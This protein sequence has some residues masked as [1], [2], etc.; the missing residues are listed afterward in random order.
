M[1]AASERLVRILDAAGQLPGQL[2]RG[3]FGTTPSS[4]VAV[5]IADWISGY[6]QFSHSPLRCASL[7]RQFLLEAVL[8]I[9]IQDQ[10]QRDRT[11]Q[12][13]LDSSSTVKK[14]LICSGCTHY[15][16]PR[17]LALQFFGGAWGVL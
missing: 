10:R 11:N 5:G 4:T 16:A 2:T 12:L 9:L 7:C 15:E 8:G 3:L 13:L 14:E 17:A 1:I 6:R